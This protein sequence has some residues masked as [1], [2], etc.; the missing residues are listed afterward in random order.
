MSEEERVIRAVIQAFNDGAPE[1]APDLFNPDLEMQDLPT[2]PDA[3]WHHGIEGA[4]QWAV[5][6]QSTFP[7]VRI[8]GFDFRVSSGNRVL[9][10]FKGQGHGAHSGAWTE[11]VGY[12]V[13]TLREAK[14][15]RLELYIEKADALEAAGLRG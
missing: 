7:D 1:R 13:G 10:A 14:L 11:I 3:G 8:E 15:S 4:V 12:G 6:W 5:K 9:F 2:M